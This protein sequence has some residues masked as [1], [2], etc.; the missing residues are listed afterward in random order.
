MDAVPGVRTSIWFTPIITTEEMKKITNNP[1]F[2]YEL[3][4]DQMCGSGHYS[5]RG[6]VIVHDSLGL[7]KWIGEQKSYYSLNNKEGIAETA[8]K[9]AAAKLLVPAAKTAVAMP[10]SAHD[11]TKKP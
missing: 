11:T 8:A 9:D 5:M 3:S 2:V 6:T 10:V 1:N 7:S 4:C